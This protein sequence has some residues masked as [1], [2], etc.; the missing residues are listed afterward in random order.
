M[1]SG[2]VRTKRLAVAA[3]IGAAGLVLVGAGGKRLPADF[4]D[5]PGNIAAEALET[6]RP[7]APDAV[8]RVL[9][10]RLRS[11][12]SHPTADRWFAIGRAYLVSGDPQSSRDAYAKGLLLDPA[13]GAGWAA[14]ARALD[15]SGDPAG[16][17]AARAYSIRRAPHDP[18]AKRLRAD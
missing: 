18:K 12:K 7:L 15:L 10:T 2:P 4:E 17:A 8:A 14:Y 1:R 13:R 3:I 5:I 9:A 11:V 6:G 16:A